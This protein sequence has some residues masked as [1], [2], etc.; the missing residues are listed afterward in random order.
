M[1]NSVNA[2]ALAALLAAVAMAITAC[3]PRPV[4]APCDDGRC[5]DNMR[6]ESISIDHQAPRMMCVIPNHC[7]NY[8]VDPGEVC[9]DGNNMD[10]DGCSADCKSLEMCGDG[11]VDPGEECD[12][13]AAK[14][15]D[16]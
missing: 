4:G 7:G 11:K 5:P 10:N 6:C 13:G 1:R 8:V 14:N 16:N 12:L 15:N 3:R 9:D 2:A